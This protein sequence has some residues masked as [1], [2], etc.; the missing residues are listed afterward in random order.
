MSMS[1]NTSKVRT[2]KDLVFPVFEDIQV[3]TRTFTA[4]TNIDLDIPKI[5][6]FLPIVEYVV[7]PKRRG[8]KKRG[9]VE[10]PNENMPYG[11]MITVDY[12]GKIRG[13]N[14]K[15]KCMQPLEG[16]PIAKG[17]EDK[18]LCSHCRKQRDKKNRKGFRNSFTVV[19]ILDKPINFKVYLNG[20]FQMTGCKHRHHAEMCVKYVWNAIK[21]D[22]SMYK[23]RTG[24]CLDAIFIPAMRN[25]DFDLGFSVDREK[26]HRYITTHTDWY[27]LLEQSIGYTGVNIQV[28]LANS[29]TDMQLHN[30]VLD[31]L[32]QEW[33]DSKVVSYMFYLDRIA[34]KDRAAKLAKERDITFLVF[35]SGRLIVSGCCASFTR[36][37]YYQFLQVIR[38]CYHQIEERIKDPSSES[39]RNLATEVYAICSM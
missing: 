35:A 18:Q 19:I 15:C 38:Q 10:N 34:V 8:R 26:L 39:S 21:N 2:G 5:A 28:P 25:I 24:T 17:E 32:E 23:I 12:M 14:L 9:P 36:P 29:I 30:V 22:T 33:V 31:N 3:S 1:D 16:E 6:N 4:Q 37:I 13:V 11:S 27:S 7:V 20:T